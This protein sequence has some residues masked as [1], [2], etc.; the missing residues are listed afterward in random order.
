MISRHCYTSNEV[1]LGG[2][3]MGALKYSSNSS[4]GI[5]IEVTGE[6]KGGCWGGRLV[7]S[8]TE[9]VSTVGIE[10]GWTAGSV[11]ASSFGSEDKGWSRTSA[12]EGVDGGW[13]R[14]MSLDCLLSM[15]SSSS[16]SSSDSWMMAFLLGAVDLG[17]R[18]GGE[19]NLAL[20]LLL[21]SFC[22]M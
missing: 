16:S 10:D 17:G 12:Q 3:V 19:F 15:R 18:G 2:C 14:G 5:E 1:P 9:W 6:V 11:V 22:K 8:I 7:S 13:G 20:F 21:L 4:S